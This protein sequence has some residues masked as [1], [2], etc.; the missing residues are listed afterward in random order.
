MNGSSGAVQYNTTIAATSAFAMS[1]AFS[2][3]NYAAGNFIGLM[4]APTY[5][6]GNS[7][8]ANGGNV[9]INGIA[10]AT[11]VGVD[12]WYDSGVD[13]STAFVI[14]NNGTGQ[15]N[16][17]GIRQT[18]SAGSF[19]ANTNASSVQSLFSGMTNFN[20]ATSYSATISYAVSWTPV[21]VSGAF[22]TGSMTITMNGGQG[23]KS[24]TQTIALPS[25]VVMELVGNNGGTST[26]ATVTGSL[27]GVSAT[28]ARIPVNVTYVD[29]AGSALLTAT[30]F[31]ADN[32]TAVG[33]T[34]ATT[35]VATNA[36][37]T[38]AAPSISGYSAV[39]VSYAANTNNGGPV[40]STTNLLVT[41][42]TTNNNIQIQYKDIEAPKMS[43]TN[44]VTYQQN[45]TINSSDMV[46]RLVT[47]LGDN[48]PKAVTTSL[49]SGS[50]NTA[51]AGT[52]QVQITATDAAGNATNSMATVKV[53]PKSV[54]AA[55]S[56]ANSASSDASS[57]SSMISSAK[58]AAKPS[59]ASVEASSA[60]SLASKHS[61]N[62]S[63]ASVASSIG[64]IA[65]IASS[66]NVVASTNTSIAKSAASAASNMYTQTSSVEFAAA[67]TSASASSYLAAASSMAAAGQVSSAADAIASFSSAS[68]SYSQQVSFAQNYASAA[69]SLMVVTSSA[70]AAVS[71]AQLQTLSAQSARRA[72]ITQLLNDH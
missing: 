58:S 7:Y 23:A 27:A 48:S 57:A 54:S 22:V 67:I 21:S 1:G 60:S 29:G 26:P 72:C 36:K 66:A 32:W 18:N 25:N 9:G 34:G 10:N 62:S 39:A 47:S 13:P 59:S 63:V 41:S 53:L 4:F 65:A 14:S 40:A 2:T 55:S 11:T 15:I 56:V 42:A 30:S 38:F 12:L 33:I 51:S 70:I 46:T 19:I 64:S 37:T 45:E 16:Q 49:T 69:K 52:Y 61:S 68:A 8:G 50:I 5:A 20:S 31:T 3:T 17:V 24:V 71:A 43:L 28:A 44:T 35:P 6:A